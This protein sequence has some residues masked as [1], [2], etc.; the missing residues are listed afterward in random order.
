MLKTSIIKNY[1]K[2]LPINYLI[3]DIK[4]SKKEIDYL[5]NFNIIKN[6]YFDHFGN[7]D[8][9][10]DLKL[11]DFINGAGNND[12]IN[13]FINI[14]HKLVNNIAKAYN[15]KY[16]WLTIRISK[17]TTIYDI[18]R[19]HMDGT[20]FI[21]SETIEAKFIIILKGPGTLF[22]KNNNSKKINNIYNN[23]LKQ[24][25]EEFNKLNILY[26]EE[27]E[28]KYKIK[29]ANKYKSCKHHQLKTR[30][31]FIFLNNKNNNGLLHSEPKKDENR[32]FIS[33]LPGSE[34]DIKNLKK[35]WNK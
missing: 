5:E 22:I 28:N 24:K 34:E 33:I 20:F 17:P 1:L 29:L 3:C 7:I 6:N 4:F 12:N 8:E 18:P 26:N 9:L 13:I 23:N 27:I 11:T 19:W 16:C 21:D 2:E 14:I 31:G 10:T 30:E 25:F 35:R 32:I 15:T